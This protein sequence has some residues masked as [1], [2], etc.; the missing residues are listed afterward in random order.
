MHRKWRARRSSYL[1]PEDTKNKAVS[2][3]KK[4]RTVSFYT[5]DPLLNFHSLQKN[6]RMD[7]C[8][9]DVNILLLYLN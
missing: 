4:K 2:P 6:Q 9:Q 5:S 8:Q 3:K 7:N 1:D